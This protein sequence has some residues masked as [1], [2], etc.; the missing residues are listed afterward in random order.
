MIEVRKV[1]KK[2][3]K[4]ILF[5]DTNICLRDGKISFLLGKNGIGKTTFVK[6][7]FELERHEGIFL[8]DGKKVNEVRNK[9]WVIWDDTPFYTNLTGM[10]NLIILSEGVLKKEIENIA[11]EY[12]NKD[13]LKRRVKSYS[14][15][16][17]KKLSLILV[18]IMKPQYLIMDEISN[19][20][21]YETMCFLKEKLKIWSKDINIFLTGHQ[22]GFYNDIVDDV[23]FF[24]KKTIKLYCED[25]QENEKNLEDIYNEKM[26]SN[27]Y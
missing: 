13:V 16:Q 24:D 7:M 25:F 15:G 18:E 6:C 10:E 5:E 4:H 12:L 27:E 1:G 22:F 3:T 23:Y 2:Y 19:G 21:D 9:S 11:T 17:R 20:L 14:Y 8:F 26:L